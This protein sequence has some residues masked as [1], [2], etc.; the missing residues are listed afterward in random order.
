[1]TADAREYVEKE[2]PSIAGVITSYFNYSQN[3][4]GGYFE[5]WK[6]HYLRTQLY[7]FQAYTKMV[8]QQKTRPHASQRLLKAYL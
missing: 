2:E 6:S 3:N 4:S 5:N 1:M 7:H 8:L